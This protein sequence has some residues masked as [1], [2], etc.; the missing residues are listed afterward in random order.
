MIHDPNTF[1]AIAPD[2]E[3]DIAALRRAAAEIGSLLGQFNKEILVH[4]ENIKRLKNNVELYGP[5]LVL[6]N[7]TIK[8]LEVERS[9]ST[10]AAAEGIGG[11]EV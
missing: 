1:Q 7:K 3:A 11:F 2:P 9:I 8:K 4:E 5:E 10:S 6:L